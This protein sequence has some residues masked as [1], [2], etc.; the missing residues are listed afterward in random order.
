MITKDRWILNQW[1]ETNECPT[2]QKRIQGIS[3]E[4]LFP[5]LVIHSITK[6][7]SIPI[8]KHKFPFILILLDQEDEENEMILK[9]EGFQFMSLTKDDQ[10]VWGY[11]T[12]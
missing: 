4:K 5:C 9:Q 6:E 2:I 3:D 1:L 12:K 7:D 11:L 10:R 8:L